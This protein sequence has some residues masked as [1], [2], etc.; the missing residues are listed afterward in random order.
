MLML[1]T[2]GGLSDWMPVLDVRAIRRPR[3]AYRYRPQTYSPAAQWCKVLHLIRNSADSRDS[4]KE[5]RSAFHWSAARGARFGQLTAGRI[6]D[7]GG[8]GEAKEG[9]NV[10]DSEGCGGKI[11]RRAMAASRGSPIHCL[12]GTAYAHAPV[13]HERSKRSHCQHARFRIGPYGK[14]GGL[15]GGR[16]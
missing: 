12:A 14:G 11:R 8:A 13:D 9:L 1:L 4:Q 15:L 5:G 6:Q 7:A 2:R 10:V 16:T 3:L